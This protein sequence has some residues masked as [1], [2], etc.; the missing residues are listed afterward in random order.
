MTTGALWSQGDFDYNQRVDLL[1][2]A[3]LQAHF[4]QGPVAPGSTAVPEPSTFA[5]AVSVAFGLVFLRVH[6]SRTR[7]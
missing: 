7:L 1:D 5:L 2:L 3:M 6:R 4:G